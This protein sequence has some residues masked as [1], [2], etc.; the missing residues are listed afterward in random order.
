MNRG[1]IMRSNTMSG[2]MIMLAASLTFSLMNACVKLLD[3]L[4][5]MELIFFR[6]AITAICIGVWWIFYPPYKTKDSKVRKKGGFSRLFMRSITGGLAMLAM[7]YNIAT[8]SLGTAS[9]FAQTM[10]I[11]IVLF[12]LIFTKDRVRL[13]TIFATIL[14]FIGV[15]C[16]CDIHTQS[17][18][19][20][21]IIAGVL[22]GIM[23]ALAYMS[24]KDLKEY[25]AESSI[26]MVF[27]LTM[28]VVGGILMFIDIPY[29]SGFA[30][31]NERE[32][33]GIMALGILGTL[34]QM[35][36]TRAFM[37][38]PAGL[39]SPL[40]YMRIVWGVILGIMLGDAIPSVMNLTGIALI[41]ISGIL[42]AMP[43]F[44]Q[45]YKKY[46]NALKE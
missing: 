6:H 15:V 35:L 33:V 30:M 42:I 31:P 20:D 13:P 19:I 24:L 29:L 28:V 43:I 34:G 39:I 23:M 36:L 21:N 41:I 22:N 26:I 11:Y 44:L 1:I 38:A 16:I 37:L 14:G 32:W 12:T 8:I 17:L 4:S 40:D 5:P 9:A 3:S 46:K 10:P 7:F 45:D 27:A 18:G 25:F 2:I